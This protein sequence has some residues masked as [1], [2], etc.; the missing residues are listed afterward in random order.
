M[1]SDLAV[2]ELATRTDASGMLSDLAFSGLAMYAFSVG[3]LRIASR[4]A[5]H[6]GIRGF[7][8]GAN[9]GAV[10]AAAGRFAALSGVGVGTGAG[11]VFNV[12]RQASIAAAS[13]DAVSDA[14]VVAGTSAVSPG[15]SRALVVLRQWP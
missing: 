3:D 13:E 5:F 6:V 1:F 4:I 14:G 7:S 9:A 15:G 2:F 11:A 12:V 8:A 10:A